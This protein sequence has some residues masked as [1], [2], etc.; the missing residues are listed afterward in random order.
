MGLSVALNTA[1]SGLNINQQ[2]LSVLSQNIANANTPGYS[3]QVLELNA[4]YLDGDGAG[5]SIEAVNRKANEYLN[6]AIVSQSAAVGAADTLKDYFNRIQFLIGK[7]GSSNDV[8]AYATRFFN[9]L[10]TLSTMPEDPT[11][12]SAVVN[13]GSGL[14]TQV[15]NLA[16]NLQD[17]RLQADQD[18]NTTISSINEILSSLHTLNGQISSNKLLGNSTAGL[19]DERDQVLNQLGQYI[20]VQ[21]FTKA[22]GQTNVFTDGGIALVDDSLHQLRYSPAAS[23]DSFIH[24][25]TLDSIKVY[26]VDDS[27]TDFG[28]PS[29]IAT[30]GSA[31]SITSNISGGSLAALLQM[32]DQE[33]PD[34]VAQLD[35]FA[36]Q[37]RDQVNATHNKGTGF[38]GSNSYT[39]TQPLTASDYSQWT[40]SVQIAVLTANGK[41][42]P[43]PYSDQEA[44]PPLTLDLSTL[45]TGNGEGY[46][47]VNGLIDVINNYY[48]PRDKVVL[49]N[50]NNI[51]LASRTETLPNAASELNFDFDLQNLSATDANFYLTNISIKDNNGVTMTAPTSTQPSYT[52][53]S[54]DT[55]NGSKVVTV[56]ISGSTS[57]LVAGDKLYLSSPGTSVGGI[58]ATALTGFFTI[59]NVTANG[60]EIDVDETSNADA[61]TAPVGT[62]TAKPPY[63]TVDAGT[64]ART[65]ADGFI[66]ANLSG[67]TSSPFYMVT[68]DVAVDDGSGNIKISTITYRINN[69]SSGLMNDRYAAQSAT[70][71]ATIVEPTSGAALEAILVD[72][73]GN[74]LPKSSGVYTDSREGYLVLRA[75]NSNYTVAINSMDSVENGKPDSVPAVVGTGRGF[76]HYFGLNN[77]FTAPSAE[78]LDPV[79]GSALNLTVEQRLI[80]KPS[81][82]SLGT[83]TASGSIP[84]AYERNVGDNSIALQLADIGNTKIIFTAT[85]GLG[86]TTRT[87]ADYVGQII[88]LVSTFTNTAEA[89]S[90][91][92]LSLLEGYQKQASSVSGV[93]LD[94]ELANTVI[95]Q[96]A[97]AASARVITVT[98]ELFSTL[99]ETFRG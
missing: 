76:S 96:N 26:G 92:A 24:D 98:N 97:Y 63:T 28:I 39:G 84:Y 47:S 95:Y 93:N 46:P 69:N 57:G 66:T 8:S 6:K 85:G 45:D 5:V 94:E 31:A 1:L 72:I 90:D 29:I 51:Q 27:G 13:A 83:L 41:P 62:A 44:Y 3:R 18:I 60:F 10:Q 49:G 56:N 64:N 81:N 99:L 37:L 91:N 12:Q 36:T 43:S 40:G 80:D 20:N 4:V 42:I 74:E 58:D 61:N 54:Y 87:L 53:A 71:D 32:R 21:T 17:L 7:P 22:N 67:Y 86:Q 78:D 11:Q 70:N 35:L 75:T 68:A 59:K 25:A 82:V 14:A 15:S 65:G 77:F 19:E 79:K 30:S 88:G 52:V 16:E 38:P 89:E 34:L 2:A 55:T 48:T 50:L 9:S 33:L 73:N 23:V